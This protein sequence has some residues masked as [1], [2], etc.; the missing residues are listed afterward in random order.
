MDPIVCKMM[1][2]VRLRRAVKFPTS[3]R[4]KKIQPVDADVVEIQAFIRV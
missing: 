1:G 2:S 4:A 3:L